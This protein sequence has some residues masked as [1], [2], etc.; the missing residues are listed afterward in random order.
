LAFFQ[1]LENEDFEWAR[2]ITDLSKAASLWGPLLAQQRAT[3]GVWKKSHA[4]KNMSTT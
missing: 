2:P 3:K 1:V 4:K